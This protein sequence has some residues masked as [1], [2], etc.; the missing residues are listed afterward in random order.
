MRWVR[1][2][3]WLAMLLILLIKVTRRKVIRL[4]LAR[5]VLLTCCALKRV[6][7]LLKCTALVL[8]LLRPLAITCP[9][10][11]ALLV[12]R[13]PP[14]WME[15]VVWLVVLIP[16]VKRLLVPNLMS[17]WMSK[18]LIRLF[19]KL[20]RM[21]VPCWNISRKLLNCRNGKVTLRSRLVMVQMTSLLLKLWI[22]VL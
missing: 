6:T 18:C 1:V 14:K 22:L 2:L 11:Y 7:L 9:L 15:M 10:W 16:A 5:L 19:V 3:M 20:L 21:C 4:G 8:V 12:T 13:V 17:R